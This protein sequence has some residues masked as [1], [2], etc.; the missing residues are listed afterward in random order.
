MIE[1]TIATFG[2]LDAA[3]NNAGVNSIMTDV[4]DLASKEYDR[5]LDIDL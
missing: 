5:I 2:R 1:K 4:A 3:Y